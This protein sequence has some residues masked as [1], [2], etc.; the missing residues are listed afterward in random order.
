MCRFVSIQL[1]IVAGTASTSRWQCRPNE[2]MNEEIKD[3]IQ[4]ILFIVLL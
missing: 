2:L 3:K 1:Y 4:C